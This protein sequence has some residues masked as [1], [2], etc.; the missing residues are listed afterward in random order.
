MKMN[1][2]QFCPQPQSCTGVPSWFPGEPSSRLS[3]GRQ[4]LLSINE[5]WSTS[6]ALLQF[7]TISHILLSVDIN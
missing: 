6:Y 2:P 4:E 3:H 7:V 5:A 1:W